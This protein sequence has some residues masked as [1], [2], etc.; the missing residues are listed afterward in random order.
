MQCSPSSFWRSEVSCSVEYYYMGIWTCATKSE[1]DE[2]YIRVQ[3]NCCEECSRKFKPSH[4]LSAAVDDEHE[5]V[6]HQ[7]QFQCPNSTCPEFY[8]LLWF[9]FLCEIN[10]DAVPPAFALFASMSE[11]MSRS[12]QTHS[13]QASSRRAEASGPWP[14]ANNRPSAAY[15]YS[16]LFLFS[17]GRAQS[18]IC[19]TAR[20]PMHG[21]PIH[22]RG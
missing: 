22:L 2:G 10:L 17:I 5:E 18:R 19:S 6:A 7:A 9:P 12:R 8:R 13:L 15:R 11:G 16:V 14:F 20:V 3:S 1:D 21:S 4:R